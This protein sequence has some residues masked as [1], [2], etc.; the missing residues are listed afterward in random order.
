MSVM[1]RIFMTL[2]CPVRFLRMD[3]QL[4]VQHLTTVTVIN[5]YLFALRFFCGILLQIEHFE[6][7][8]NVLECPG[9]VWIN[10]FKTYSIAKAITLGVLDYVRVRDTM[11]GSER[12]DKQTGERRVQR[13]PL[14]WIP[15]PREE[16]K[17]LAGVRLNST[18]YVS[19]EDT[20]TGARRVEK[21]PCIWFPG[22]YEEWEQGSGV[23]LSS[24][25]YVTVQNTFSG[26]RRVDKGPCVWFPGPYDQW[27]KGTSTSL[28]CTQYITVVNKLTG[29]SDMVK[30]PCIWFPGP[31]DTV[32]PVKDAIVLQ[33]DEY[34]IWT[35][36]QSTSL[37]ANLAD[38]E[39]CFFIGDSEILGPP[40]KGIPQ[41]ASGSTSQSHKRLSRDCYLCSDGLPDGLED[42]LQSRASF[43]SLDWIQAVEGTGFRAMRSPW[44]TD[45]EYMAALLDP[46][47]TLD[48]LAPAQ[49]GNSWYTPGPAHWTGGQGFTP[50]PTIPQM[51]A[52]PANGTRPLYGG[53]GARS[54]PMQTDL[55]ALQAAPGQ[56]MNQHGL[57][58]NAKRTMSSLMQTN[59]QLFQQATAIHDVSQLATVQAL[60]SKTSIGSQNKPQQLEPALSGDKA[61]QGVQGVQ[62]MQGS[63]TGP[64]TAKKRKHGQWKVPR[65][66]RSGLSNYHVHTFSRGRYGIQEI[67]D[68]AAFLSKCTGRKRLNFPVFFARDVV[69]EKPY[70]VVRMEAAVWGPSD[71]QSK[72]SLSM[73]S[74]LKAAAQC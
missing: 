21:G 29:K 58:L 71:L 15:G 61:M 23:W 16:G 63:G 33:D 51:A 28:T 7:L 73:V 59:P 35:I 43:V 12:A 38:R 66:K 8:L 34:V 60:G 55:S 69:A 52:P 14:V 11:D 64:G 50:M 62:G 74:T 20:L 57:D 45:L 4:R 54:G 19:V 44:Q 9:L 42:G 10:P 6:S 5:G 22:P 13:G 24:T 70:K 36:S 37:R 25:E 27:T 49:A 1:L 3:E 46:W 40:W 18:E 31:Y 53:S 56:A 2:M 30:G 67:T 48:S 65:N 47:P 26:E 17:V 72:R 39:F 41:A 68:M 32:S